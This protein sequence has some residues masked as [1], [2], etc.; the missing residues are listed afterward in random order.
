MSRDVKYTIAIDKLS[1]LLSSELQIVDA[2]Y[3]AGSE[4]GNYCFNNGLRLCRCSDKKKSKKF[5]FAFHV[6]HN[7]KIWGTYYYMSNGRYRFADNSSSLLEFNNNILYEKGLHRKLQLFLDSTNLE[8]QK[9]Y[10]V[11]LAIDGYDLVKKHYSLT[12]FDLLN[13]SQKILR[14]NTSGNNNDK[15]PDSFTIGSKYSNKY[16][17]VY[18]KEEE[19]ERSGKDYIKK[20]WEINGL[21]II[22]GHSMDR[23]EARFK[24]NT[25]KGFC[26]NLGDLDNPD[27]LAGF[28]K[29]SFYRFLHFTSKKN[30]NK[31]LINWTFFK[32]IVIE[33]E[34]KTIHQNSSAR[35]KITLHTLFNEYVKSE[36]IYL[37]N[38]IL[39]ISDIYLL[40]NWTST[41]IPI[42]KSEM[43]GVIGKKS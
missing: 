32:E 42:W 29:K 37:L 34:N 43:R 23:A 33:R 9:F 28:Y 1:I 41:R 2:D 12:N 15:I 7:N 21:G 13:R 3:L 19:L 8:F 36:N 22:S 16:I 6:M 38:S 17:S 26:R 35:I 31:D 5:K 39:K 24:K 20:F 40:N 10:E 18:N 14:I 25:L 30:I 27:Y 11:H 4:I